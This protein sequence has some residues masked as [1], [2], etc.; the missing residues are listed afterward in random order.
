MKN[1]LVSRTALFTL[2]LPIGAALSGR[3]QVPAAPAG[4]GIEH[5][6]VYREDGRFAGW[7]ANGGI[8][9]WG[10]EILVGFVEAQ[11]IEARGLHTYD[12]KT[13]RHKYARSLDGGRTWAVEDAY[14]AGQTAVAYDHAIAPDKA[15]AA[16]PLDRPMD[17]SHP[18]FVLALVRLNNN[19]D[20]P[21]IFYHSHDKGKSWAGPFSFPNLGTA[22]VATRNDYFVDDKTTLTALITTAKAN[23][24]EGRVASV[25][26]T[27]GGL[28]WQFLS[29]LGEEHAGFDIMPSSERLSPNEIFTTIRTRTG[30][31]LD[32]MTAHVSADNGRTWQRA[33]DPV[34]DTGQGG[35]PPALVRLKDGRLALAY[36]YRS[37][38]GS[39]LAVRFSADNG[40]SWGNEIPLR[41][42]DGANRDV[43]YPAMLQRADGKLLVIYYWNNAVQPGAKPYRYLAATVFDPA[44]WQ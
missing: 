27:D 21:S 13:A 14:D 30:D 25:R 36:A 17:F 31:R 29:Y 26:T 24:K 28:T 5:T 11:H 39:R 33:R 2:L 32:L 40:G 1:S 12:P 16:R 44:A 6:V 34:A 43:G 7:P 20:G 37:M 19:D 9:R 38:Y 10:D 4:A 3:A 23:R 8:W 15:V 18:G 41:T 22:G 42:G 35:S